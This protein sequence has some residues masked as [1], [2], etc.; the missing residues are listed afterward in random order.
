M[1]H[2]IL[3]L[4]AAVV[5]ICV[6]A[7]VLGGLFALHLQEMRSKAEPILNESDCDADEFG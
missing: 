5:L 6:Y 4:G 3:V 1:I 2:E 7:V